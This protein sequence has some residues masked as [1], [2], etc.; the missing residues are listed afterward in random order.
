[1]GNRW[2]TAGIQ[3]LAVLWG[4]S[5]R[6]QRDE[7]RQVRRTGHGDRNLTQQPAPKPRTRRIHAAKGWW[8]DARAEGVY[9]SIIAAG[10]SAEQAEIAVDRVYE[11]EEQR[12]AAEQR[13][14]DWLR[15]YDSKRGN[16]P[17][18]KQQAELIR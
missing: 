9:K 14:L 11:E 1:M 15:G 3:M 4:L 7:L 8:V 5:R 16:P 6:S 13:Y 17:A 12:L 2:G 10:Y 18:N